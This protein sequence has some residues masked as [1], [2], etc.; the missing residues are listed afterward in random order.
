MNKKLNVILT[1]VFYIVVSATSV[2]SQASVTPETKA[3]AR[4]NV[5]PAPLQTQKTNFP[6]ELL[7][8]FKGDW[9]GVGRFTKSGK[10]VASD[11]SFAPDLENQS[12]VVHEK[13]RAPNTYHFIALWSFDSATGNLMMFLADDSGAELF[14]SGSG[15][16]QDNK[17]IFQSTSELKANSA[18]VRFTFE[19][20]SNNSFLATYE[21]SRDGKTWRIG[22]SQTFTRK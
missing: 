3:T 13:E 5:Q 14:R 12:L 9:S 8:Y 4:E 21:M 6:P 10:E 7:E 11:F 18:L 2:L 1:A 16:W 17:I 19:R 20:K 22:D 15:C